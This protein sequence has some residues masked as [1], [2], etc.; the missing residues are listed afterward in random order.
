MHNLSIHL[1]E[2]R[3]KL[4]EN[5]KATDMISSIRSLSDAVR[6]GLG[7]VLC[8]TAWLLHKAQ[9]DGNLNL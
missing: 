6:D 7:F 5:E 2:H 1:K 9:I 8:S 3:Q 4:E